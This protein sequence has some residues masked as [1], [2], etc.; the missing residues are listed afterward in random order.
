[1]SGTDPGPSSLEPARGAPEDG[2]WPAHGWRA[3]SRGG[4]WVL[5]LVLL[6]LLV[7]G[8]G[9]TQP[10]NTGDAA[11]PPVTTATAPDP[12][13]GTPTPAATL[14]G[15]GASF[16]EDTLG[17][18]LLTR[19]DVEGALPGAADGV[20]RT[21]EPGDL[22][23][24]LPDGAAVTP[25]ACTVALSVVGR[26]PDAYDAQWWENDALEV[27]QEVVVLGSQQSARDAFRELVTAVDACPR[28]V[29][30]DAP[31]EAPQGASPSPT[32]AA[33]TQRSVWTTEPAIEGRGVYPGIVQ[34][35]TVDDGDDVRAQYRGY[36][37]V[38][39]ALVSWTAT[40]LDP[41]AVEDPPAVLGDPVEVSAVVQERARSAVAAQ[42]AT[43]T[44]A[45]TG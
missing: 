11:P 42:A 44:P 45:P 41:E 22:A 23:W 32:T 43:A 36:V 21:V 1:M 28:Y 12:S 33:A 9:V 16:D 19:R 30:A 29:L 10:W 3:H 14:P 2:E 20:R 5:V 13:T 25:P 34:E 24:G 15:D 40:A 7:L 6:A 35:A 38:G 26:A 27:T 37:L 17:S 39:N 31:D 18:L 4:T 8:V